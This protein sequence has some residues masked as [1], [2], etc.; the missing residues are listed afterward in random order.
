MSTNAL[1]VVENP[2][3]T[4]DS[5]YVHWDGYPSGVGSRLI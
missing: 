2:N 5:I 3:H 1:I 4:F